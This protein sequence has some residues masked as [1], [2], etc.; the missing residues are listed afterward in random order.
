V[1]LDF[2]HDEIKGEREKEGELA[3][4]ASAK[5]AGLDGTEEKK[6]RQF[7]SLREVR[8]VQKNR[9]KRKEKG[10][11]QGYGYKRGKET[12]VGRR[13][14]RGEKTQPLGEKRR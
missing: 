3:V 9:G 2:G 12:T 10:G 6:R 7:Y 1:I 13:F 11:K 4:C 14:E 8:E 5:L